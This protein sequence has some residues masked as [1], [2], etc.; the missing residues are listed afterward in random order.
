MREHALAPLPNYSLSILLDRWARR[1][2]TYAARRWAVTPEFAETIRAAR[3]AEIERLRPADRRAAR[4]ALDKWYVP[5]GAA[6]TASA[7]PT[8][9]LRCVAR[10]S[11]A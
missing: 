5:Q 8:Y 1:D 3:R 2:E 9:V 10:H 11:G 4:A 7:G 6:P